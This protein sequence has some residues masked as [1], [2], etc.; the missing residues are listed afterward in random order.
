MTA[1]TK[2]IQDKFAEIEAM[3]S[4]VDSFFD[5]IPGARG[6]VENKDY[7]ARQSI[8]PE[9]AAFLN[10]VEGETVAPVAPS[11]APILTT[12][13]FLDHNEED[14]AVDEASHHQQT[15]TQQFSLDKFDQLGTQLHDDLDEFDEEAEAW[16]EDLTVPRMYFIFSFIYLYIH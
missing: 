3:L 8:M 10:K 15:T 11:S 2:Q 14:V 4:N 16:L 5:E 6:A 12:P 9:L 1:N 13:A 7:S